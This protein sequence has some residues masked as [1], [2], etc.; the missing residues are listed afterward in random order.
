MLEQ[1][2]LEVQMSNKANRIKRYLRRNYLLWKYKRN[3]GSGKLL[4]QKESDRGLGLTTMMINDCS[5][6]NYYLY[7]PTLKDKQNLFYETEN[8]INILCSSDNLYGKR[9]LNIVIDNRC[10]F[11]DVRRLLRY[12]HNTINIVNGF[13]YEP[14]AK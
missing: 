5:V 1:A 10:S 9:N 4:I 13:V 14:L 3:K 12:G 7:V 8:E 11:E 6:N 2:V